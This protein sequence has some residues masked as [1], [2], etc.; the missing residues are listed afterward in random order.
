MSGQYKKSYMLGRYILVNKAISSIIMKSL[1]L[2]QNSC[3]IGQSLDITLINR[4]KYF[5]FFVDNQE[6]LRTTIFS[7]LFFFFWSALYP[8]KSKQMK[9]KINEIHD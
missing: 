3:A 2:F 1:A 4:S 6:V 5:F 7:P 8:L 9:C